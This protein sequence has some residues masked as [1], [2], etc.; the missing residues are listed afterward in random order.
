MICLRC[1]NEE[2]ETRHDPLVEQIFR[3]ETFY[4][5]GDVEACQ[6]CGWRAVTD[7]QAD[8]IVRRTADAFRKKHGLLTSSEIRT[9]REDLG[10]SQRAFA[11]FL[12]VGEASVKRWE[13]GLV[14]EPVYDERIR[15]HCAAARS[16]IQIQ[17]W[18]VNLSQYRSLPTGITLQA[19]PSEE[20][21]RVTV[22]VRPGDRPE[23]SRIDTRYHH[24]TDLALAA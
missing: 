7:S 8:T 22:W 16:G 9:L 3:G 14:Q 20:L 2:F 19:K 18:L 13:L 21:S 23:G 17:H 1:R 6:Q 24:D 4:V 12:K 11:T 10:M 5:P 15:T